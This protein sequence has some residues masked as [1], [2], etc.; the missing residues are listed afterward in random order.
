VDDEMREWLE[1]AWEDEQARRLG[2]RGVPEGGV[3]FCACAFRQEFAIQGV[4]HQW[5]KGCTLS[6]HIGM[7]RLG[8]LSDMDLKGMRERTCAEIESHVRSLKFKY[9]PNGKTANLLM[10]ARNIDGQ[11]MIL[12]EHEVARNGITPDRQ[13]RGW[14]DL[15]DVWCLSQTAV[16][17]MIDVERTDKHELL[18]GLGFGHGETI[19][20]NPALL[21][22]AYS[23]SIWKLQP[24][25]VTELQARYDP[26][27]VA[28]PPPPPPGAEEYALD[29]RY[30]NLSGRVVLR[31]TGA[32]CGAELEI[33]RANKKVPLSGVKPWE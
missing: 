21:E 14:Y 33:R 30:P 24:R 15:R 13:L 11:G 8:S 6:W 3:L 25:D 1:Q 22:A 5:P 4:R 27:D 12:A 19:K 2:L 31:P 7:T 28:P 32:G 9:N 10:E 16:Q 26:A 17:G 23:W 18:H 29:F 20:S